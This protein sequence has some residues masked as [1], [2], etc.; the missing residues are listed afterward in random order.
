MYSITYISD[1]FKIYA[2]DELG[3]S[4]QADFKKIRNLYY[5]LLNCEGFA[6]L[7]YVEMERRLRMENKEIARGTISKWIRH[8]ASINY[9]MLSKED[10][11]YYAVTKRGTHKIYTEIQKQKY[12]DGW[13]IYFEGIEQGDTVSIA[14]KKMKHF[15]GGH[16]LRK[17][18]I[19]YNVV[20]SQ[21]L[22]KLQ[23]AV[24][25]SFFQSNI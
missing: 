3:I 22:E 18:K 16:P 11:I 14:Y 17:P 9:I 25:A 15:I 13:H 19:I 2:I 12:I 24:T 4:P 10:A 21:Q 7:P 1:P 8:L 20:Y 23:E 6:D 5:Y